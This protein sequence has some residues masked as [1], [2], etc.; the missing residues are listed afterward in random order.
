MDLAVPA[1]LVASAASAAV[2]L[3]GVGLALY[4]GWRPS[5]RRLSRRRRVHIE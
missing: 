2:L 4:R 3:I 1:L 5:Y